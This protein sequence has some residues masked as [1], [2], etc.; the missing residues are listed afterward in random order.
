[1]TQS[2]RAILRRRAASST[3]PVC[4]A[5]PR[6]VR[7]RS[8]MSAPRPSPTRRIIRP[9]LLATT[10]REAW[11]RPRCPAPPP[12]GARLRRRLP[13]A[14]RAARGRGRR[15]RAASI[16]SADGTV[17]HAERF[18]PAEADRRWCS[19]TAG[20]RPIRT[21]GPSCA[22]SPPRTSRWS[23]TTC[24]VTEQSDLAQDGDY[25]LERFGEDL[26]AVLAA[27]GGDPP[28]PRSQ[29]TRWGRCRSP[30]GRRT[31]MSRP[32]SAPRR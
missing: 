5:R 32:G 4:T 10:L 1:M 3:A 15:A 12:E 9:A 21:G 31:T 13:S 20:P 29:V 24:A 25:A 19:P 28:A 30:R 7:F 17:L 6:A 11:R 2:H 26:E 8:S 18:G 14:E 22:G 16:G 23:P 27:L